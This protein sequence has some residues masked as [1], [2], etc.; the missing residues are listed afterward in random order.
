MKKYWVLLGSASKLLQ[1][2]NAIA[3]SVRVPGRLEATSDELDGTHNGT[4]IGK[5]WEGG[6][7][8]DKRL[9][10][11]FLFTLCTGVCLNWDLY[12]S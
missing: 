2:R 10:G 9:A 3:C 4:M 1:W 6:G 5:H 11:V 12:T 8:E 7:F